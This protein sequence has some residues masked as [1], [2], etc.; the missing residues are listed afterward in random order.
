MLEDNDI[1]EKVDGP[2][3]WVSPIV[4][5]PKPHAPDKIRLCVD[6][7]LPNQAIKRERHVTPTV[8][9][10]IHDLNG[11]S[12]FSKLDLN[13]GYHQLELEHESRNITTFSTH[14]GLRRYKRLSFG[15]S[16]AAELFQNVISQTLE[17]IPG[18]MNISDDILVFG[19]TTQEHDKS[20]ALVFQRLSEKGLTLNKQKCEFSKDSLQFFGY[21]FTANG[22]SPDPRK[23]SAIQEATPPTNVSEV[24][25]LLGMTNYCARFISNYANTTEPLRELIH[26]DV[27]FKWE[28][29]HQSALET[30][31]SNLTSDTVM[32]YFDQGN[33]TELIV[34][35]SP[36][37][38]GAILTQRKHSHAQ[39]RVVA[40][41][42]RALSPVEQRYSQ[43]EREA[44]AV[45]WACEHFRLYLHG[46]TFKVISDHKP[47]ESII[48]NPKSNPPA[49]LERW[50]LRLQDYNFK[51]EYKP[52][53]DNPADYMSRHPIPEGSTDNS[54]RITQAAEEYVNF[55]M[56]HSVPKAMTLKEIREASKSD[57]IL[58]KV[59]SAVVDNTWQQILRECSEEECATIR[60]FYNIRDELTAN[61][62]ILLRGSRIV[63]PKSLQTHVLKLAHEGHQGL[64]KTKQLLREKVWFPDIDKQAQ[65]LVSSCLPC[66]ATTP[67]RSQE[68]LNMSELPAAPWTELSIDFCGPFPSGDYLLVIIDDYSRYPIVE[69]TK[70][71]S[72]NATIPI[73]DKVFSTFGIP[74]VVKSDNGPPF[75]GSDFCKFAE[76]L[77]F[78]HRKITPLWPQS[79]ATAERFMR[80][81][82]KTIRAAVINNNRSWRQELHVFLRNYRATPHS[83][84]KI[85]PAELLFGRKLRI[86]LPQQ[87]AIPTDDIVRK[88][89]KQKMKINAERQRNF[90]PSNITIG[91]TVLVTQPKVNKLTPT[92]DPRPFK[93]TAIKGTMITA[94]RDDKTITRN[95]SFFKIFNAAQDEP[96]LDISFESTVAQPHVPENNQGGYNLRAD[97]KRPQRLVEEI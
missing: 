20:L 58:C 78:Q 26:K 42:S 40:Y 69:S 30:L 23:V 94:K 24:R 50:N 31:K 27:V 39:V 8:D 63:I 68:F 35:A 76:Y 83:S 38:L 45:V 7:R 84:T 17:G 59:S 53:K 11:S 13:A 54:I 33:H 73:L 60:K 75:Q 96:F 56:E 22:I 46:A 79:N 14:V 18:V 15:I 70:S 51:L 2:T 81:V 92:Y 88:S 93:V 85:S 47:L 64:V 43:T 9:E 16:S 49:R 61:K 67:E 1:I 12:V 97:R 71:T 57:A 80:T 28:Q 41:A 86:K 37:G 82:E 95:S 25:S 65:Q 91:D 66:N 55:L 74:Q 62:D 6:M 4:V 32:S 72:A 3:P 48:N 21:V 89:D 52:G 44:L 36:V 90:K 87:E 5:V 19:K 10:L 29:K 34:D 77:G